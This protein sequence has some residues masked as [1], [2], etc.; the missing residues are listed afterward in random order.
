MIPLSE[1]AGGS[2]GVMPSEAGLCRS[3]GSRP[4]NTVPQADQGPTS[5]CQ[6]PAWAVKRKG[7]TLADGVCAEMG[8]VL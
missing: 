2:P 7:Q 1:S 6:P 8:C 5:P 3:P 4:L